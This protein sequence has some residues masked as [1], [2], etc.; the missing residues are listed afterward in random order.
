MPFEFDVITLLPGMFD[1][2]TQYGIT[3]K[4]NKN[5]L[6]H[7]HTWNPRDYAK[8]RYRTV[9][10]APYGGGPG[11]V[12]MAEPLDQAI[13]EA[14][15]WQA[16]NA[17]SKT[18][19]IYLSP[20]GKPLDH[21]K[22]LQLAALDGLVLLCGR[23]EGID[24]RLIEYQV[25]EEVSIGDYVISGGELAAMVL[26][27]AVVRQLPGALGDKESANQDSLADY[28]LEYPQYTRP[29]IYKGKPVPPVLLSGNHA[30]IDRWRLQQSI[31]KTWLK[32]PDLLTK[33]YPEGLPSREKELLEEFKQIQ[34]SAAARQLL[35]TTK[36]QE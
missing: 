13:T 29:E 8:N 18:R 2:V 19:V 23:Y 30:Q 16:E 7:L 33:K 3:G 28:L 31:G 5:G 11:M 34:Y 32:R 12:M 26:I 9:D 36:G 24:E 6:Y 10:D 14:K 22:I 1:A 35:D 21:T 17:A 4:A 27:D 20:Q 15:R 25:E